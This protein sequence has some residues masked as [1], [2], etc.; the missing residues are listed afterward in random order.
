MV[1]LLWNH[2]ITFIF[3]S[4][5][6]QEY[7]HKLSDPNLHINNLIYCSYPSLFVA[8]IF[9]FMIFIFIFIL[10][11]EVVLTVIVFDYL[12]FFMSWPNFLQNSYL[13]IYLS[14]FFIVLNQFNNLVFL[15]YLSLMVFIL[16]QVSKH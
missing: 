5:N 8:F 4:L 9:I 13:I 14:P 1:V 10:M 3:V 2:F 6:I 7:R 12:G 15:N 11:V 16:N